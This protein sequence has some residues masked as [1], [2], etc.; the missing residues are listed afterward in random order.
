MFIKK[1]LLF[2]DISKFEVDIFLKEEI[3]D[4]DYIIVKKEKQVA[5]RIHIHIIL[6]DLYCYETLQELIILVISL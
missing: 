6:F 5:A 1:S 2:S 3:V 4:V